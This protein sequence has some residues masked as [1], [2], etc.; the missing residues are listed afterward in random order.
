MRKI[1]KPDYNVETVFKA[2]ISLVKNK[3]LKDRLTLCIPFLNSS[4]QD[5]SQRF[6]KFEIY[7]ISLQ[8]LI[9]GNVTTEE[10]E[11]VYTN[12]M[13][14]KDSPGRLYYDKILA[15]APQGRCPLC[16]QRIAST[17]DHYLPK[18]EFPTLAVT[19]INLIPACSDCNK[20]KQNSIPAN[21]KEQTLHP[22]F[23][24]IELDVWLKAKIIHNNPCAFEFYID[25]PDIW[26]ALARQRI[27]YH[28][29]QLEI[30]KL[31]SAHA[32]EEL[33]NISKS[34]S[35]ILEKGGGEG[36]RVFLQDAADSRKVVNKN[37]WQSAIYAAMANDQ[38]FYDGGFNFE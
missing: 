2:C 25:P 23:D 1:N 37:S 4:E 34:L 30:Q 18:S 8:T 20:I 9:N 10:M 14:K 15:S 16:G 35:N 33:S 26:G 7:K 3:D 22:Y 28:F 6:S 19:P 24:D 29:T 12:R 11:K 13:A 27:E 17:L 32:A 36:V 38:W 5:F 21:A 31:Y